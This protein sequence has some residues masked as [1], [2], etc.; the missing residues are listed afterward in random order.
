MMGA[1]VS[2]T[3]RR[4]GD[5][6]PVR[7]ETLVL[8]ARSPAEQRPQKTRDISLSGIFVETAQPYTVGQMVKLLISDPTRSKVLRVSAAVVHVRD[9]V[10]FGARF[11]I[12]TDR[13]RETVE[14]FIHHLRKN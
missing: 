6:W 11:V 7:A 5:R 8:E 3:V 2:Y 12:T 9:G 14:A 4:V 10:G 1:M 13:G